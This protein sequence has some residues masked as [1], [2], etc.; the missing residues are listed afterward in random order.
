MTGQILDFNQAKRQGETA[1]HTVDADDIRERLHTDPQGFVTWLYSG[2]A[3][4]SK[5]E[6]RIGDVFGTPGASLSIA[7]TGPD[8]GLWK[9]HA[10]DKGGDLIGL[11]R[12]WAG[13]DGTSSFVLSLKEIA[14]DYFNDPIEVERS[15]WQPS[16]LERIEQKKAK[17]GTSPR[18]DML[19]LGAP[20][21]T[22]K[23]YD[24]HGNVIASVV[25][26]EPLGTRESKTFRPF[27]YKTVDGVTKWLPGAPDL[28]PLYRIPDI[29][30]QQTIVLCEGEGKA[31]ALT[32]LGI[33]ATSAMQGAKAPIDKTDWS[34]LSGKTVIIWP[35]NDEPGRQY[36]ANVGGRLT[37][38]GCA[39]RLV[40]IPDSAPAKW[41]AVDCIAEGGDVTGL[42]ANAKALQETT[43]SDLYKLYTLEEL[44]DLPP[45]KYVVDK[46]LIEGTLA[47]LWA[48]SDSY[49]T[50]VSIDLGM[51]IATSTPWFNHEVDGGLVIY[52]A[53]ED[54]SGVRM[55]MIGWRETRGKDIAKANMV[56]LRDGF[57]LATEDADKLIKTITN[58]FENPKLIII[59]TL[60]RTFGVG[61]ENQTQDMNAYVHS[62]DKLRRATGATVLVIHH[63]GR[64]QD[65]ERGNVALRGACDTIF[66]IKKSGNSNKIKLINKPPKGKQKN[67]EPFE[68]ISLRM[69]QVHFP[70]R[71]EEQS[72]LVVMAD[73]DTPAAGE[74]L[75][76]DETVEPAPRLGQIEKQILVALDKAARGNRLHLGFISLHAMVGGDKGSFGRSLRK[77]VSKGVISETPDDTDPEKKRHNYAI[78]VRD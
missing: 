35:D 54:E 53:A 51:R 14:K 44:E 11:Y 1:R 12:A 18:A 40:T 5:G 16:A 34:P 41:D 75:E 57:T 22:Y 66:T 76:D 67:A 38:L 30:L 9:D 65:Q 46:V 56:L 31:E 43:R 42:L 17:L 50:F 4:I 29:V 45:P 63:T 7:L 24:T 61:N 6:A 71:G 21:A 33:T 60:Q 59:D 25:R 72:T 13:Y 27:C 28:R 62:A 20:V 15:Q 37:A 73:D 74:P 36:A 26:F 10:T 55:R 64:N 52:I 69:Q 77:L 32:A 68:D 70:Y 3:L 58:G 39:V 23:Y 47:L 49:K 19:E 78:I 48:G 8:K 2:R